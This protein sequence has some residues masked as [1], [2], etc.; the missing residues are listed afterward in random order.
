V[1]TALLWMEQIM[2]AEAAADVL[3]WTS[4]DKLVSLLASTMVR[5]FTLLLLLLL[6]L[7]PP[8]CRCAGWRA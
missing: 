2:R 5:C 3:H 4:H 1:L 6:L 7:L 8:P